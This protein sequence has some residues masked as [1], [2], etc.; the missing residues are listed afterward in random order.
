MSSWNPLDPVGS[1]INEAIPTVGSFIGDLGTDIGISVPDPV[2]IFTE[3]IRNPLSVAS[4]LFSG[5]PGVPRISVPNP[6]DFI[7]E[8]IKSIAQIFKG[9]IDSVLDK[10]DYVVSSNIAKLKDAGTALADKF[11]NVANNIISNA[12]AGYE[13]LLKKTITELKGI[14]DKTFQGVED[15]LSHANNFA[16]ARINQVGNII[17]SSLETITQISA[18]YAPGRIMSELVTPTL[19]QISL[20][21]K[22]LFEDV[23]QVLDKVI[24][25]VDQKATEF[26]KREKL[27]A[28]AFKPQLV[29]E[30]LKELKLTMPDL[31][32]SDMN[33][34]DFL[35]VYSLKVIERDGTVTVEER[36]Q[37]YDEIRENAGILHFLKVVPSQGSDYYTREYVKYGLLYRETEKFLP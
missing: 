22:Q 2:K 3:A 13:D 32:I 12:K 35:K 16:E 8:T 33:Y 17:A 24:E 6:L 28:I 14:L 31:W 23:N 27:I 19:A 18:T 21:E 30:C 4:V 9:L 1:L 10:V 5:L 20:M 29:S 7:K 11:E 37:Y 34:Y 36:L 25:K 15:L 26:K